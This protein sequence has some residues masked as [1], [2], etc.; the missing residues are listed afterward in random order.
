LPGD[1]VCPP[2]INSQAGF[3]VMIAI[4]IVITAGAREICGDGK[5]FTA[6]VV[7]RTA[8][9]SLKRVVVESNIGGLVL[10]ASTCEID[11]VADGA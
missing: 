1:K 7:L 2:I 5:F 10:V 8:D 11:G 4:L 3:A 9:G 6:L